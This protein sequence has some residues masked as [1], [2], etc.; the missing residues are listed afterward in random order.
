MSQQQQTVLRVQY[1]SLSGSTEYEVLDLYSSVPIKIINSFAELQDIGKKN[2]DLSIGIQLPGSKRNN[3]FFE[4]FFNVDTQSLF[5]NATLKAACAVLINDEVYFKGYLRLNKVSVLNS[6]VEYDVALYSEVGNLFGDIGNNLLKELN[7]ADDDYTFN[8]IFNRDTVTA[9]WSLSNF[10]IDVEQ[11]LT[12]M[13]PIVHNGYIYSGDTVNFSGGTADQQTSLYT[14][15]APVGA[16]NTV[17][18]FT[19]A[20][21]KPYRINTPY[22][23][24]IDNQLKPALSVWN[25]VKLMFKTYGYTIKS[26][27]MNTPWMKAL[28]MYGYF[29]SENTKFSWVIQNIET[30]PLE[31]VNIFFADDGVGNISPVVTTDTGIPC[32]C[33]D[34][35]AVNLVYDN[36][37]Y[38]DYRIDNFPIY[39]G[40]S[41]V[42]FTIGLPFLYGEVVTPG[43]GV[44]STLKY[45]PAPINSPIVF[46]DGTPVEFSKVVDPLI[47]QIDILSSLAKKFNLVF[48]PD[49][50]VK[51]QIIIESY[52]Y[53]VGTGDIWDWTD[54]ISFDKGFTVEPALNYVESNLIVTDAD[55]GDYGNQQFKTRQNRIYGQLNQTNKTDYKSQEKKIETI[56]GPE[57]FRQWDT[58]DQANNGGIK[59]PLGINYAGSSNTQANGAN[60]ESITW[61]Y[62]GVKT[63]PK[64]MWLLSRNNLF[65]DT[66]NEVYNYSLPF[67]T[68]T[69]VVRPSNGITVYTSGF[70]DV[71]LVSNTMPIGM[72][73]IYKINN[74]SAC[75]LFNS[76]TP[77]SIDVNTFPA[78]TENDAYQLFYSNRVNN[79]YDPNT[80]FLNGNFYLKLSEY[81]NLKPKDVIKIQDQY[82][83]L[84]KINGYNLTNTELTNVELVQI[85]RNVSYYPTRYF[86]Y[87]YCDQTGYTFCLKTDFTNPSMLY[88]NFG[89]SNLY[90]FS[91]Q[92]I[93]GD[94]QPTGITTSFNV[95][96]NDGFYY[97]IPYTLTEIDQDEYENS[98]YYSYLNDTMMMN[99]Y[100]YPYGPFG[101]MM[102]TFWVALQGPLA[103]QG[104]NLFTNCA[105]F[106][107]TA[108]TYG[109][110]VGSSTHF[111]P[112][113]PLGRNLQTELTQDILTQNND[114]IQTQS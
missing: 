103:Y 94:T 75:L 4:N 60:D 62:T 2:S 113:T 40:T 76:E 39:K 41:G 10:G 73:D 44:G 100:S 104:T 29:S 57:I 106:Y 5:F 36:Y 48:I 26:D 11:P 99:V 15:T 55:D 81:K 21:G 74:D 43:V 95:Q 85:N 16:F 67:K 42:T 14:S 25:L 32:F 8:H 17:N 63:K 23:G 65:V 45:F 53:Y 30:L 91:S 96:F 49:P 105:N 13:Y 56:F 110:D 102:P 54:K 84:N 9:S 51:N 82:F 58:P 97:Y 98:G 69:Y 88:T 7:F 50:E 83:L 61:T 107:S 35:I 28:Y 90:D 18:A 1:N 109:I 68:Y 6:K 46:T 111:G 52:S 47:K 38:P 101:N 19:A 92:V 34:D 64:L 37:P 77:T 71:P 66:W 24:I 86:K 80:R 114:N 93:Y 33:S 27:F 12:Y 89:W 78:Y 20:G 59:L 22:Q 87:Q 108:T 70:E 72:K 31:S 112:P 79:L 3:R